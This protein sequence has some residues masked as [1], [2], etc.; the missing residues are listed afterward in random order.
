VVKSDS[1]GLIEG[2]LGCGDAGQYPE[3]GFLLEPKI[4]IRSGVHGHGWSL[5]PVHG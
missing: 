3:A 2:P 4:I 1:R 5:I